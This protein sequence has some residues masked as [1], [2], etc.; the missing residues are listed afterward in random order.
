MATQ[1][2]HSYDKSFT[3][4]QS[5]TIG[6]IDF[7]LEKIFCAHIGNYEFTHIFFPNRGRYRE[8]GAPLPSF[9]KKKVQAMILKRKW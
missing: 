9:F 4:I 5:H 8:E 6:K 2:N 3:E 1:R 7:R